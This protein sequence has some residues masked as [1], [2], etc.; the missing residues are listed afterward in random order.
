MNNLLSIISK[1]L[2]AKILIALTLCVAIIMGGVILLATASQRDQLRDQMT[3]HGRELK[4][5]A[6]AAIRH[7]M[8]M[9]DSESVERQ[10]TEIRDSLNN[11]EILIC[12]FN[13]QI[14]FA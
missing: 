4:S 5:L 11:N 6:Y 2:S 10:L 7:P 3:D 8:A 1:R 14:T 13:R 9:G 12:D